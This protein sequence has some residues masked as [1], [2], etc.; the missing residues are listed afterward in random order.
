MSRN[1]SVE[2]A[3]L[4]QE[5]AAWLA[6]MRAAVLEAFQD[7]HVALAEEFLAQPL[8]VRRA[9]IIAAPAVL[10][11]VLRG[12][13]VLSLDPRVGDFEKA[14]VL[15]DGKRIAEV[16]P[17]ISAADA[18]IVDCSGTI[19][20]SWVPPWTYWPTSNVRLPTTP[21]TAAVMVVYERF[22][23]AWRKFA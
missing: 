22:S 14:D 17:T 10:R 4:G 3:D 12:G 2:Q 7:H 21:S 16:A 8:G 18:E 11:I 6:Q 13:V 9:G 19:V 20:M 15:I 1:G 5:L 23:S